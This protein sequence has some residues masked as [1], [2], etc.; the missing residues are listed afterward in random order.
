MGQAK[1]QP[2]RVAR[3]KE[4]KSRQRITNQ[5]IVD[6]ALDMGEITSLSSVRRVCAEGSEQDGFRDATL[7]PIE[8]VLGIEVKQPQIPAAQPADKFLEG[9]IRELNAQNKAL[10]RSHFWKNLALIL[11]SA[12]LTALLI[13]DRFNP[14]VGWYSEGTQWVWAA[15][16]AF[17]VGFGIA[18]AAYNVKKRLKDRD[19]GESAQNGHS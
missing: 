4:E 19:E 13:V 7:R 16:A 14:Y 2:D 1:L 5:E 6:R 3:I 17:L 9:I 10:R 8:K 18:A 11:L 15:A 12:F